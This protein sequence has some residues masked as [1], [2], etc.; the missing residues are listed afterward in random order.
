VKLRELRPDGV[1]QGMQFFR[2]LVFVLFKALN[3]L[4]KPG[5]CP[6]ISNVGV[7]PA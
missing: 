3:L 7:V 4:P 6:L 2:A 1:M 5:L